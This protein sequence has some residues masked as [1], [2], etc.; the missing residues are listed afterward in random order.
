MSNFIRL[1]LIGFVSAIFS[2]ASAQANLLYS[3][4]FESASTIGL[5]GVTDIQA[6][7]GNG[8]KFIGFLN[9]GSFTTLTLNTAGISRILLKFDLYTLESLDGDSLT[10]GADYFDLNVNSTTSLLR[11]TFSNHP[12][13][14]FPQSFG[15]IG[16][17]AGMGS[18]STLTGTLGFN[19][20]TEILDH[21]YHLTFETDISSD[22]TVLNFIGNTTQGWIDEGFGIDNIQVSSVP[23]PGT[24]TLFGS[25]ILVF[26][27]RRRK[28]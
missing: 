18:D 4:D 27:L 20:T 2:T 3:N 10:W 12:F 8:Q 14:D 22:T 19:Y 23:I 6:S 15:G 24:L 11:A 17:P 1:A 21:T 13:G 7:P 5:S 9:L 25:A 16:S 26:L 28:A